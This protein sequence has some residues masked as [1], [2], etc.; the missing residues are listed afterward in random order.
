[1]ASQIGF[2]EDVRLDVLAARPEMIAGMFALARVAPVLQDGVMMVTSV[3]EGEH[4]QSTGG[5]SQHYGSCAFDARYK[6]RR[7]GGVDAPDQL[8]AAH[9]WVRRARKVMGPGWQVMV[10]GNHLHAELD[11]HP[12]PA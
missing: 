5:D 2:K 8:H 1:M 6:G 7:P 12:S 4:G 3:I 9:A 11:W 10:H